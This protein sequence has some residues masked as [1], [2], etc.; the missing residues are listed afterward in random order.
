M[1]KEDSDQTARMRKLICDCCAQTSRT[2]I[3]HVAVQLKVPVSPV[4]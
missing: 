1:D 4:K 2:T 3:S